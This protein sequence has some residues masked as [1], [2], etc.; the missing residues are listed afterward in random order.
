MEH[1]SVEKSIVRK[2][3]LIYLLCVALLSAALALTAC[4]P[5][6]TSSSGPTATSAAQLQTTISP[7]SPAA[8]FGGEAA[9]NA[10]TPIPSQGNKSDS[11]AARSY[12]AVLLFERAADLLLAVIEKIQAG[13]ISQ[14]DSVAISSYVDAFTVAIDAFNQ[15]MPPGELDDAWTQVYMAAQQYNQGYTMLIRGMWISPENL[16][17]LKATRKLLARDQ[18]M[19]EVYLA[20]S[21]LGPDFFSA[22]QQAVDQHLQQSYGD[23]PVPMLLP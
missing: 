18:E 22:Q 5:Q 1:E 11:P 7:T 3:P 12:H 21:G 10:V 6:L 19:V 15:A 13:Q 4:S 20:Q 2:S 14:N 16:A 23:R 17:K 9:H 8:S